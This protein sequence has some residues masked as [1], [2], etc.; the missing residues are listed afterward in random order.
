MILMSRHLI[1]PFCCGL[2]E[3]F[4][5]QKRSDSCGW[6]E[7]FRAELNVS[8]AD[9]EVWCL[10][11]AGHPVYPCYLTAELY[12]AHYRILVGIIVTSL[13]CAWFRFL[14][15]NLWLSSKSNGEELVVV[16][17]HWTH[18]LPVSH[19]EEIIG[20]QDSCLLSLINQ[21]LVFFV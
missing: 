12:F 18:V 1:D 19:A 6:T 13:P 20:T 10:P 14:I 2:R 11:V 4:K 15:L 7:N 5:N 16:L 21:S 17:R 9:Q 8:R 3:I